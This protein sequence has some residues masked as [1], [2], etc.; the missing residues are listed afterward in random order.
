[1]PVVV[2]F[3]RR[4]DSS[5]QV[6]ASRIARGDIGVV[7]AVQ[8][9]YTGTIRGNGAHALDVLGMM[10]D[11]SLGSRW[12]ILARKN[13][14]PSS[15]DP[16]LS[17]T[18][19][20][21]GC[22]AHMDAILDADYFVYEAQIYG[23]KGRVRLLRSGNDI[24]FD[25]PVSSDAYPGYRY[26]DREE[27]LPQDTLPQSFVRA[28]SGLCEAVTSNDFSSGL[29]HEHLETLTLI[30]ELTMPETNHA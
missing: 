23:T 16:P 27:C 29:A 22:V 8:V 20:R 2:N 14:M 5:H 19:S 10:V 12:D 6:A 1:V 28:L 4:W 7:R 3:M 9:A 21:D 13:A 15:P 17:F 24:R 11:K 30:D 26:L 18:L 25:W